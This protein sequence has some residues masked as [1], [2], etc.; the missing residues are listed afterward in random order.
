MKKIKIYLR[1]FL[2]AFISLS[3]KAE[4]VTRYKTVVDTVRAIQMLQESNF[5]NQGDS[6]IGSIDAS[7]FSK[8]LWR[9]MM[10]NKP[11]PIKRIAYQHEKRDDEDLTFT[12]LVEKYYNT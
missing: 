11:A 3:G 8:S 1:V 6:S 12:E 4:T 10:R 2:S 5:S 9:Q 7:S